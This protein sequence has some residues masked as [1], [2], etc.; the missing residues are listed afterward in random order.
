[1]TSLYDKEAYTKQQWDVLIKITSAWKVGDW[2]SLTE[3]DVES[4]LSHPDN[5]L[6]LVMIA[7]AYSQCGELKQTKNIL[8][9]VSCSSAMLRILLSGVYNTLGRARAIQ[10]HDGRARKHF[11]DSLTVSSLV[12]DDSFTKH[13]RILEQY[14]QLGRYK[15]WSGIGNFPEEKG[16]KKLFIDCGGYDGCSVIKFLLQNPEYDVITFEANPELWVYY[17]GLPGTL[18]KKAVYDYDG[19]IEFTLDPIDAD[20]SSLIKEKKIDFSQKLKNE[21]CPK[22]VV[23]CVN[24]SDFILSKAKEYNHIELKLDVEGA[25]YAILEAM[26]KDGTIRC[27]KKL[28]AEFHWNKIELTKEYHDDLLVKIKSFVS[29]EEWDAQEFGVYKRD[30]QAHERRTL[31][32]KVLKREVS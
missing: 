17:N 7:S 14:A 9:T 15:L 11:A 6:L 31:F 10:K 5:E 23:E 29:I 25:E 2:K 21:D 26:L 19:L 32:E 1:M 16:N 22:L 27:I 28:Y 8:S 12:N 3:L 24:L 18:I 13:A 4:V 20:G 30:R